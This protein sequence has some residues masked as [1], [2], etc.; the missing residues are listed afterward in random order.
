MKHLIRRSPFGPYGKVVVLGLC[1]Y[2]VVAVGSGR[3]PTLSYLV[4][5]F[6]VLGWVLLTLLAHHWF[7][8]EVVFA[9]EDALEAA[10]T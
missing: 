5:K 6:P 2:E 10:D 7:V 3:C 9:V 8:E 1:G 4:R